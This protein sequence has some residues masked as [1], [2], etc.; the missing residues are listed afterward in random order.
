MF[1]NIYSPPGTKAFVWSL[2]PSLISPSFSNLTLI[3]SL[4][5]EGFYFCCSEHVFKKETALDLVW[6]GEF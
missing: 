1:I 4:S 3:K 2:V 6:K 5:K